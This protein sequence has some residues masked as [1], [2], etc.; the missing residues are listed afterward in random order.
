[1]LPLN[2]CLDAAVLRAGRFSAMSMLAMILI[3]DRIGASR[4]RGGLSRSNQ[5]TVDPVSA[6]RTRSANGSM[7]MSLARKADRLLDDQV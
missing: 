1:V 7:W 3:R 2:I 5:H 6:T 4:R